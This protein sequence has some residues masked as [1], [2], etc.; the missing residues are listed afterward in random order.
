MEAH[1][2]WLV[3]DSICIREARYVVFKLCAWGSW[4]WGGLLFVFLSLVC[5]HLLSFLWSVFLDPEIPWKL[6]IGSGRVLITFG[7][8][9]MPLGNSLS[10]DNCVNCAIMKLQKLLDSPDLTIWLTDLLSSSLCV[11]LDKKDVSI[12]LFCLFADNSS[13]FLYSLCNNK[14]LN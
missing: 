4:G 2:Y 5:H 6:G 13:Q 12:P 11:G 1:T 14:I 9:L 3:I 7:V 10:S 8:T